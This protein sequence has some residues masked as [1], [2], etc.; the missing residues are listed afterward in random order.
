MRDVSVLRQHVVEDPRVEK[1]VAVEQQEGPLDPLAGQPERVEAVRLGEPVI[2]DHLGAITDDALHLI[3]LVTDD[4][5]D[6]SHAVIGEGLELMKDERPP[7]H[8][9]QRLG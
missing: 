7:T 2:Q 1:Q 6:W 3:G 9:D 5:Q 4:D 8:L